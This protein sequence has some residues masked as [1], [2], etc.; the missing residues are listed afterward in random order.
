MRAGPQRLT[1]SIAAGSVRSEPPGQQ[2][3]WSVVTRRSVSNASRPSIDATIEGSEGSRAGWSMATRYPIGL[4]ANHLEKRGADRTAL[5]MRLLRG[6]RHL[7]D[8]L[9][10]VLHLTRDPVVRVAVGHLQVVDDQAPAGEVPA[11]VL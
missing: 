3:R 10:V 11:E 6:L 9:L 8:G 2:R 4:V 1:H 5:Q 7:R